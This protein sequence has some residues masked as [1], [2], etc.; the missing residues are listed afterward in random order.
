MGKRETPHP[1]LRRVERKE[2][3]KKGRSRELP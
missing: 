1:F 2:G 3:R